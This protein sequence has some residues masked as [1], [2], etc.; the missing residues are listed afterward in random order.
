MGNLC[1]CLTKKS[2]LSADYKNKVIEQKHSLRIIGT[3]ILGQ[4]SLIFVTF[5]LRPK[6]I[7]IKSVS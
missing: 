1:L 3:L 6:N 2:T 4:F 7:S 5:E